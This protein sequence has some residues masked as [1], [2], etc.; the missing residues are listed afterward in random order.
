MKKNGLTSFVKKVL[1]LENKDKGLKDILKKVEKESIESLS[2]EELLK[3][4]DS[5]SA[6]A[7]ELKTRFAT[8]ISQ[9]SNTKLEELLNQAYDK[10]RTI[11]PSQAEL[12]SVAKSPIIARQPHCKPQIESVEVVTRVLKS[13]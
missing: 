11:K 1:R 4:K 13:N 3:L 5:K 2:T 12:T 7:S 10:C 6:Y 8:Q 9:A